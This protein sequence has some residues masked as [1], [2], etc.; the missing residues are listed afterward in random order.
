[1]LLEL[2]TPAGYND[3]SDLRFFP[4][5]SSSWHFGLCVLF[6]IPGKH[7][8]ICRDYCSADRILLYHSSQKCKKRNIKKKEKKDLKEKD[9]RISLETKL[10]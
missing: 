7:F 5:L 6:F 4:F 2:I 3:R 8:Q 9:C 10:K 1:V